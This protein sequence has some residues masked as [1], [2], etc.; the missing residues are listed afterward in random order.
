MQ[1]Y[2]YLFLLFGV[3]ILSMIAQNR[4]ASVFNQ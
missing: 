2:I 1:D 3:M 4:V